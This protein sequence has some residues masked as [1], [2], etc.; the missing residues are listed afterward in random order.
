MPKPLKNMAALHYK[1]E[2]AFGSL[3]AIGIAGLTIGFSS[4]TP[5]RF[6]LS[7]TAAVDCLKQYDAFERIIIGERDGENGRYFVADWLAEFKFLPPYHVSGVVNKV[8]KITILN[9]PEAIRH[10][11]RLDYE[12]GMN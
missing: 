7:K 3:I 6:A 4:I 12:S 5:E 2:I 11:R 8:C 1:R 10:K 9:P